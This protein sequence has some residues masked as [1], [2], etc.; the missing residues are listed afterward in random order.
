MDMYV[1]MSVEGR[2]RHACTWT[3]QD[4][5]NTI[6]YSSERKAGEDCRHIKALENKDRVSLEQIKDKTFC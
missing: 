1:G 3:S 4:Q 2:N 5:Q 6:G